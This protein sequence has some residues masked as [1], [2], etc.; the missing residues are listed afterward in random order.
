MDLGGYIEGA[1]LAARPECSAPQ[2]ASD[3]C[4]GQ[5]TNR[6]P[7]LPKLSE[8][9]RSNQFRNPFGGA[10]NHLLYPRP[11]KKYGDHGK[12]STL[13]R[14]P[15][16]WH[17]PNPITIA[18]FSSACDGRRTAG[19]GPVA[20]MGGGEYGGGSF[21]THWQPGRHTARPSQSRELRRPFFMAS[22]IFPTERG[23]GVAVMSRRKISRSTK[24]RVKM[25]R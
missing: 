10:Y 1:D 15:P 18:R 8:W 17:S 9:Y 7:Q 4:V 5:A 6:P 12:T 13:H 24:M 25:V 16:R 3:R 2:S 20:Y 21:A 23:E 22:I 14:L 19:M 11:G